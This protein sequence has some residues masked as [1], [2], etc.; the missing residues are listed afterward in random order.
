MVVPDV[1]YNF[2]EVATPRIIPRLLSFSAASLASLAR[3]L[4][5]LRITG[6]EPLVS[7]IS[8]EALKRRARGSCKNINADLHDCLRSLGALPARK[9]TKQRTHV[10]DSA[11][12]PNQTCKREES[13]QWHCGQELG[14]FGGPSQ[15]YTAW[16]S[17]EGWSMNLTSGAGFW[18]QQQ[19]Y[20]DSAGLFPQSLHAAQF[21]IDEGM[22]MHDGTTVASW[23]MLEPQ[24]AQ[25]FPLPAT[26]TGD[27]ERCIAA[28]LSGKDHS[29]R[30]R[31]GFSRSP[32]AKGCPQS[33]DIKWNCSVKNSFLHVAIGCDSDSTDDQGSWDGSSSLCSSSA[34]SPRRSS[35]VPSR[36]GSEV[37]VEEWH[38]RHADK[39][40]EVGQSQRYANDLASLN[41]AWKM[42]GLLGPQACETK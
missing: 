27:S 16:A 1:V 11:S 34:P 22:A 9:A 6:A 38:Q 25:N 23:P 30:G 8:D 40:Q 5:M 33:P 10:M 7:A 12:S 3:A 26:V 2:V 36:L 21:E 37:H 24:Q 32:L 15:A 31:T 13:S 41:F 29:G 18:P 17:N 20:G 19:Q 42:P 35:S 28:R 14:G 39:S 4:V